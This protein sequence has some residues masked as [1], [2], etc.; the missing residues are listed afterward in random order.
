M[1]LFNF[2]MIFYSSVYSYYSSAHFGGG[3][4][5]IWL[6]EPGCSGSEVTLLQCSHKGLGN[7]DCSHVEG[8]GLACSGSK[9]GSLIKLKIFSD[10]F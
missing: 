8:V 6:D 10:L 1:S 3:T 5:P 4:G 9:T 2:N 7:H